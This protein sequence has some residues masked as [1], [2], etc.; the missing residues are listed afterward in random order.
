MAKTSVTEAAKAMRVRAKT[1]LA[2]RALRE[3]RDMS[4]FEEVMALAVQLPQSE[5]ERLG[6]ALGLRLEAPKNLF[7]MAK[8]PDLSQTDPAAWRARTRSRGFEH[9]P[10]ER[11]KRRRRASRNVGALANE[12]FRR[13]FAGV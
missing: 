4:P 2:V 10:I 11:T 13:R 7:P 12:R 3:K 1:A 6:R 5:R 9:A 8:A